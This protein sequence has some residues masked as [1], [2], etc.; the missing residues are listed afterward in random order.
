MRYIQKRLFPARYRPTSGRKRKGRLVAL[1]AAVL[2]LW[3]TISE[4]GLS[5]VSQE[6]TE[7]AA[8]SYLLSAINQAVNEEMQEGEGSFVAVCKSGSGEVSAVSADI[9]KLNS[10]K[11]GVMSRLS[12]SLN[13]KVTAYVPVGSLTNV[14]IL[15]GRGPKVPIKLNLESSADI[16]FQTEFDSAGVNQ[17]CHRIT[18]TVKARTYSQSQRFETRVEAQTVTVLAETVIVGAVPDVALTGNWES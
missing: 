7:E 5:A 4:A 15:N 3:G 12:K 16:S 13:G 8:R 14:G 2:L 18:M 1:A 17:S 9:A 10:L 11:T 6:L